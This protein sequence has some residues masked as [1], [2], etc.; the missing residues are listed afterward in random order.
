VAERS[1]D[2][3]ASDPG[4]MLGSRVIDVRRELVWPAVDRS[5]ASGGLVR[6]NGFCTT[7]SA[8]DFKPEACGVSTRAARLAEYVAEMK[9]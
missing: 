8:F 5:Q 2:N 7:A 9:I 6:P 3:L 1:S 4:E